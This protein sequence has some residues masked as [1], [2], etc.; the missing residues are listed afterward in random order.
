MEAKTYRQKQLERANAEQ[1]AA[2]TRLATATTQ[3]EKQDAD[4][5]ISFWGNK[6]AFFEN[7]YYGAFQDERK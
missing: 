1:A 7:I 6:L 5:D 4:D 2:R 3:Q